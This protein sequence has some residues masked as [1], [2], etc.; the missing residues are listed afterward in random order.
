M[1][2]STSSSAERTGER[3][4]TFEIARI[5]LRK[6]YALRTIVHAQQNTFAASKITGTKSLFDNRVP[7]SVV[8][9]QPCEPDDTERDHGTAR[10]I[11]A[12]LERECRAGK[13]QQR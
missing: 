13:N 1:A 12:D 6:R 4:N 2:P 9:E 3:K 11:R 7:E 5:T 10:K 8:C